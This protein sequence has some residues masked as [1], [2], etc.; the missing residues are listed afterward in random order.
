MQKRVR[1]T[2]QRSISLRSSPAYRIDAYA[3]WILIQFR[4]RQTRLLIIIWGI[5]KKK[6]LFGLRHECVFCLFF[7]YIFLCVFSFF[8]YI[9]LLSVPLLGLSWNL[10]CLLEIVWLAAV[11]ETRKTLKKSESIICIYIYIYMNSYIHNNT[12]ILTQAYKHTDT[13]THTHTYIY[14]YIYIYLSDDCIGKKL[15]VTKRRWIYIYA[16]LT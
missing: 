8:I 1:V 3:T 13:H 12:Y 10:D 14:I 2:A 5:T 15:T 11:W 9:F 6:R 4:M 7:V 16:I